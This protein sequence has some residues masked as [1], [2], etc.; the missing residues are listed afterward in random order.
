MEELKKNP[1]P[2]PKRPAYPNYQT[3]KGAGR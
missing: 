2:Q 1:V 3:G